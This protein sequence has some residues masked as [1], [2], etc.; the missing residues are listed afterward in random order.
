MKIQIFKDYMER[1]SI[2]EGCAAALFPTMLN[3][4]AKEFYYATLFTPAQKKDFLYLVEAVKGHFDTEEARQFYLAEWRSV[5]LSKFVVDN[6]GKT[7]LECLDL[8]FDKLVKLQQS[9]TSISKDQS[10][11]RDQA[12]LACREVPECSMAL[13]N[14]APTYEGVRNQLRNSISVTLNTHQPHQQFPAHS[15]PQHSSSALT[16]SESPHEQYWTDRTYK[17]KGREKR[18][19]K[20][21]NRGFNRRVKPNNDPKCHV[22]GQKGCWSTNH[23]AHERKEAYERYKRKAKDTSYTAYS[24]F[25]A[26][27][28]GGLPDLEEKMDLVEQYFQSD[29]EDD[30][31]SDSEDDESPESSRSV[32]KT[33]FTTA[34]EPVDAYRVT[35]LLTNASVR[36]YFTKQDPYNTKTALNK[37]DELSTAYLIDDR[38]SSMVFQGI[39]PDTGAAN[40]STAGEPQFRA[41]QSLVPSTTLDTTKA[42]KASIR[43]GQGETVTSIG[44]TTVST[45]IGPIKF[46]IMPCNTPFLMCL[47]DMDLMGIRF[48]NLSNQLT[49]GDLSVPIIRKWGHPWLLLT[50]E[51]TLAHNYLTEVEL[52]RLHR[53]FGHPSV[54]RLHKVLKAAGHEVNTPVLEWL[55]KVCHQCQLNAPQPHRFKF[56]LKDDYDFN[57]EVIM[58][59]MYLEGKPVLH[60]IDES[61]AFGAARFLKKISTEQVW[62]AL[63]LCWIDTYLGPPDW[64]V[65][66]A[67]KQFTSDEF[68][69]LAKGMAISVKEVPIEA[70]HSIGKSERYHGPLRRAYTIIRAECPQTSPEACL[71]MAI[72]AVNDTAGPDGIVPTL[73]V[74]GAYPRMTEVSAPSPT[75]QQRAKAVKKAMEEVRKA[76]AR[77]QV[78]EALATRNG[79][80]TMET[81]NLPLQSQVRVW[82]EKKGWKGP[83]TLIGVNGEDVI[84]AMDRG[85]RTFRSTA[86]KPYYTDPEPI[87]S[88]ASPT[89]AELPENPAVLPEP[90]EG[91]TTLLEPPEN[92]ENTNSTGRNVPEKRRPGRPKGSKNKKWSAYLA[93]TFFAEND[94]AFLS[95][96]EKADAVLALELRAKGKITSPGEPFEESRQAEVDGLVKR[97]VFE[98]I[99]YDRMKHGNER[100][101]KSRMVDEIKA[102]TTETPYEKSRLIIQGYNDEDKTAIL[103][104]SPT[105]QRASQR[106]ILSIT[107]TLLA[108]GFV[109]WL[110]DITQAYTQSET[111]LARTIISQLPKQLAGLYPKD[112]VMRVVRP[113]YGIAEA[114]TH[115]WSTYHRHH[116]DRLHMTTST[117]DPCLLISSTENSEFACIGMQTD[118]TL[119]LSTMAFSNQEEEKLQKAQFKAKPKQIL[120]KDEP[121]MF[122]GGILTKK[123]DSIVITQKGQGQKLSLV[124]MTAN[125]TK[126]Q[127]VRQRA[128]GAYIASICQPEACFDLSVAA[129]HQEPTTENI[130]SLNRRIQWQMDHLD[131]GLTFVPLNL[132]TAKLFIF[133][134]GSFANNTDLSS[135]LGFAIILANE[136]PITND[137]DFTITGNLIHFSS[138]KSKRVTRSVLASEIYGMVA[139]VDMG[140]AI[141]STL[142]QITDHLQ[143]PTIPMIVCTDSYSLY[144]CL[145]KLG[146]TKEKRLMIDIMALR[147]SYERREITEV[148][149]INGND[150]LADAFTKSSPN[151]RLKE[152]IDRNQANLR[153]E[154]WVLR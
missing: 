92:P 34:K 73:L 10:V 59:I 75:L 71:Q 54:A 23:P 2:P 55:T 125:D 63:R 115:W 35:T 40:H 101:F 50:P 97:G 3:E 118:D 116:I 134:D 46:H 67:G 31:S 12:L 151:N 61:T 87:K 120:T 24:Q 58:D 105:I 148:R 57:Y 56:T 65:T 45:P 28:E 36:H 49:R 107:P 124:D 52:R 94:A 99:K 91:A 74:F 48:D 16:H 133:V 32:S 126:Q 14:P 72:K 138:T 136:T 15:I 103:T 143:L 89:H 86:V 9:V 76:H 144:E 108:Q 26:W 21:S 4:K 102:K 119:G 79:P 70:H 68:R 27:C 44:R 104:Q 47:R 90:T 81:T 82:R 147:Q 85:P 145:V 84:L 69:A 60:V 128:R 83:Y 20:E 95:A 17:G 142:K 146:T 113:L 51:D 129:Q 106:I 22:C 8:M 13:Y 33:Y 100:I 78:A 25:V 64:I 53:R 153:V 110:R 39:L 6:P 5:T 111:P 130:K 135:Q 154:G 38:Y 42:G 30:Y 109:I 112:T 117:Y 152:F 66:D 43:F 132:Q 96:K 123:G 149:W 141:G 7:K 114:G 150:N 122:N 80:S 98:F 127:Y 62:E 11:L 18:Y 131:R 1:L 121:L 37:A 41:L 140:Y 88:T 93:C 29:S 137:N 77:R 19:G 139:G